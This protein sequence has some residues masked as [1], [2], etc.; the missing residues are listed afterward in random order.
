MNSVT[1]VVTQQTFYTFIDFN[2]SLSPYE[3]SGIVLHLLD[4]RPV[5]PPLQGYFIMSIFFFLCIICNRTKRPK[6]KPTRYAM[7]CALADIC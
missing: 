2:T 7:A 6:S 1:Q 5:S 4:S 3:V